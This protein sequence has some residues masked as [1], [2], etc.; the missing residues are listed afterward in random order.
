MFLEVAFL[1]ASEPR[2]LHLP[3][4]DD[5]IENKKTKM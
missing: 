1:A 4:I 3:T 5:E 2:V